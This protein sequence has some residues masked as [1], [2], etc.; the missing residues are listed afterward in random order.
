ME[1]TLLQLK[2]MVLIIVSGCE[3]I[4]LYLLHF[5]DTFLSIEMFK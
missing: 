5:V 4:I 3:Y 2:N 1:N